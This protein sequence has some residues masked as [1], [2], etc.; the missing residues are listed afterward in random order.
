MVSYKQIQA[1]VKAAHGFEPRTC[2][3]AHV[4]EIS[5]LPVRPV[6]NR[7]GAARVEPCPPAK[8]E[9]IREAPRHFG[10]LG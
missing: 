8:V 6:W 5:G 2:W 3:I 10:M 9:A 4:K 1:Y 7:Q